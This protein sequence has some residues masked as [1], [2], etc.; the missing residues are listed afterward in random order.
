MKTLIVYSSTHKG[1]TKKIASAMAE[2][3]QADL[4]T[5]DQVKIG[6]LVNYDL[7]GFGSG[8]Y[9]FRHHRTILKFARNLPEMSDKKAFIFSTSGDPE[10]LKFHQKLR[11]ILA[12]KHCAITGEFNCPG[13]DCFGPFKL[14]GGLNQG[15]PNEKDIAKAMAFAE[16]LI[17]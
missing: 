13:L 4:K 6:E 16:N 10:G 11:K 15:R 7:I 8:I 1:N 3:L 17:R 9:M 14:T 12:E 5:P 2:V